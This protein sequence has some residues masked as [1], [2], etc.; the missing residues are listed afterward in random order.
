M[1]K[2]MKNGNGS[3]DL[4]MDPASTGTTF[5]NEDVHSSNNTSKRDPDPDPDPVISCKGKF[6]GYGLVNTVRFSA[7][8]VRFRYKL[9]CF[10]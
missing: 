2:K 3:T 6:S 4:P 10:K 5:L 1:K 8:A 9:H 7:P